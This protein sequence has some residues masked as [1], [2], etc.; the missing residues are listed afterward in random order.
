M[1]QMKINKRSFFYA[2]YKGVEPDVDENGLLTGSHTIR[3]TKPKRAYANISASRGT[4]DEAVFGVDMAYDR[5]MSF[6]T[7]RLPIDETTVLWIESAPPA[8]HDY[9]VKRVAA[10]I[11]DTLVAIQKVGG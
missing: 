9:I 7:G 11:N 6:E 1:R 10:H 4:S 3:R 2:N 5:V 8:S